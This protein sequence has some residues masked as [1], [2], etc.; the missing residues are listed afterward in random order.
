[1]YTLLYTLFINDTQYFIQTPERTFD[2]FLKFCFEISA[3]MVENYVPIILL[4]RI[5]TKTIFVSDWRAPHYGE[6]FLF[7]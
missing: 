2:I 4:E 6:F 1:M 3:P 5:R 7:S